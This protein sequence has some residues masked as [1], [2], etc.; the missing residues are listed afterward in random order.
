MRI[1]ITLVMAFVLMLAS[2]S[3]LEFTPTL[4]AALRPPYDGEVAVLHKLPSGSYEVLGTVIVTGRAYA[5]EQNMLELLVEETAKHGANTVVVQ[6][7]AI[8]VQTTYEAQTR[9]AGTLIWRD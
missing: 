5:S 1:R 8:E 6:G 2:C 4:S 9:L 3:T 7:K